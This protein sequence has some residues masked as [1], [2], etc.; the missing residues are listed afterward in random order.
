MDIT[1]QGSQ[2]KVAVLIRSCKNLHPP[3]VAL[4]SQHCAA[5]TKFVVKY[6]CDATGLVLRG[7]RVGQG[8]PR[9]DAECLA[10]AGDFGDD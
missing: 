3:S 5:L 8:S 6:K 2:C 7:P 9:P 4:S 1:I 10:M